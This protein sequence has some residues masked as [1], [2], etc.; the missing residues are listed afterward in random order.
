[1]K[2]LTAP[3]RWQSFNTKAPFQPHLKKENWL[4]AQKL[5]VLHSFKQALILKQN[6]NYF[7]ISWS[8]CWRWCITNRA[9]TLKNVSRYRYDTFRKKVS[10]YKIHLQMYLDTRYFWIF[11]LFFKKIKS[12]LTLK[13]TKKLNTNKWKQISIDSWKTIRLPWFVNTQIIKSFPRHSSR[14]CMQC[15]VKKVSY[16]RCIS[17][18][19]FPIQIHCS[20]I[21]WKDTKMYLNAYLADTRYDTP[22]LW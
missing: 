13:M 7:S 17:I 11:I 20:Q 16:R 22:I 2:I 18:D 4:W 9:Y 21:Q 12:I 6:P 10:R 1:M 3:T 8:W 19:T 15:K 14:K 5:F